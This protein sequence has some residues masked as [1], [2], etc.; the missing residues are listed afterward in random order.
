MNKTFKYCI[1]G[2][3]FLI[4]ISCKKNQVGGNATVKGI[5]S[6]HGKA[7]ANAYVYI[8][9]DSTEFPGDDY[10]I[11]DT[12]VMADVSGNYTIPFYKGS[13]FIYAKGYDYQIASPYIVK[14]G[15]SIAIRDKEDLN[16]DI[17]VSE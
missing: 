14:G 10:T 8:K 2:L 4:L 12:Y 6:H 3:S 13:Y 16:K 15:L 7:I 9:Y 5:V 11:Y 1:I 17:A